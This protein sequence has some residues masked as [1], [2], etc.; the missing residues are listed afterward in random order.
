MVGDQVRVLRREGP[1]TAAP[2][3]M[4]LGLFNL[5]LKVTSCQNAPTRK[6]GL[7]AFYFIMLKTPT[8][9]FSFPKEKVGCNQ[10]HLFRKVPG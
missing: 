5:F 6:W 2:K 3:K 4:I 7:H 9:K 10:A 8:L 1:S